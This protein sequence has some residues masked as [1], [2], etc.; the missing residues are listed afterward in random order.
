[1]SRAMYNHEVFNT[2]N[3]VVCSLVYQRVLTQSY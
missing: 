3:V 2:S 1:M